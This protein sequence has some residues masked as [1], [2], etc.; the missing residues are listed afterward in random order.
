[1]NG[2]GPLE[3][4]RILELGN[5][6]A[7]PTASCLLADAGADV[8]KVEHP[9][10]GDDLRNWPPYKDGEP[11]WWKVTNR[12]K[13]LIT[14]NLSRPDA[15][16]IILDNIH[17]FDAVIE[18]FRPGTLEKWNLGYDRLASANPKIV[19]T[20][21]SGY[22]QT[23]PYSERPGYG[24]I[25]EAMSGSGSF[26]G[27]PENPPTL[28]AFPLVDSLA[29]TFAALGT[30]MAIHERDASP[31]GQGQVVD[32]SLYESMFR[33]IDTQ[34]IAYDQLGLVKERSGNR[35]PEDSPRNVYETSDGG[36]VAISA[37]SQRTFSRLAAAIGQADLCE[38]VRFQ[39]N[40]ARVEN[41]DV[42]DKIV[43]D[44][45]SKHALADA[46]E[47]LKAADVVAGPIYDVKRI[48]DD[49]QYQARETIA[50]V[51]DPVLGPIRMANAFPKFSRTPGTIRHPGL[52]KGFSNREVYLEQFGLTEEEYERLKQDR[53]I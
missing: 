45:F 48:V 37:G 11:L 22:G 8:I 29:G 16:R 4:L 10:Y 26:S 23:G 25:A 53:V 13:R 36:Y 1:M 52:S 30:L 18:N 24:T 46:L 31:S 41:A 44:W 39:D 49:P 9:E 42:L 14:L 20:R 35:M 40:N 28:S 7:A 17:R 43:A 50:T 32:V 2:L 5:L 21:L 19:L 33:L 6:I 3:G 15:Q 34:V 27:F 12:N 38:D 47:Q 51:E